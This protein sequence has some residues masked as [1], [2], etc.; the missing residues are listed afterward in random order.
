MNRNKNISASV[1]DKFF[2]FNKSTCLR[3]FV[4]LTNF[5]LLQPKSENDIIEEGEEE[6][7]K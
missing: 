1:G 5:Y 3:T 4:Q 7:K 2:S 6:E